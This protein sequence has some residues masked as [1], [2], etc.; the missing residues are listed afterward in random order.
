MLH[1]SGGNIDHIIYLVP[2]YYSLS[3]GYFTL[4]FSSFLLFEESLPDGNKETIGVTLSWIPDKEKQ[5]ILFNTSCL[6]KS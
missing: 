2:E 3:I 1:S 6:E 4:Y 5:N